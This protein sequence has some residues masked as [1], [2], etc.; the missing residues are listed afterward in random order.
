MDMEN[1]TAKP[2]LIY[3]DNLKVF[4]IILVIVHH[5]GQAYGP[6]GGF[7]PYHSSLHESV[8]WL[9]KFFAV[10][11]AFF[12]GLF[13]MISGYFFPTAFDKNGGVKFVKDRLIRFGIP[14]LFAFFIMSPVEMYVNYV[15][16]SGN[17]PLG[18]MEYFTRIFLGIG[19]KPEG[20]VETVLFPEMNFGHLWF[21]EHLL[22]YSVLYF[23]FRTLCGNF[24]IKEN[25]KAPGSI[26][27]FSM[28]ALIAAASVIV[29]VWYPIDKWIMLGGFIQM[30]VAHL[31]QYVVMFV[32][33]II[34]SRKQWFATIDTKKGFVVLALGILMAG[35]TYVRPLPETYMVFI[36]HNRAIYESFMAVFISWGLIVFFREFLNNAGILMKWLSENAY[37]AYIFH[38]PVVLVIQYMLDMV[39]IGGALGKFI[40]VSIISVV[41]TY[42]LSD[43]IRRLPYVKKVL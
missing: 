3:L 4:L 27:I 30:E 6:T 7:W 36:H 23:I 20:F 39:V 9:G 33:G 25:S 19:G 21:V 22:I 29:R 18:Y 2:R 14:L 37:A 16:Y 13:F 41:V 17:Q 24:K 26:V 40:T 35:I 5:V 32:T 34:A 38:Y 28:G 31:P 11:A 15:N 12:M 43:I 10:N 8:S 42:L 1:K